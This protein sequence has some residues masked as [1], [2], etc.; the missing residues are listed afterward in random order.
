[1]TKGSKK[2]K[3]ITYK[4]GDILEVKTFA[5]PKIYKKVKNIINRESEWT[6][7]GK[8]K[9]EGFEGSFVRRKDLYAL[10]KSCVPYTGK[11]KLKDTISFTYNSQI[12]RV[13]S[14]KETKK[15]S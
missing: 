12:I 1:V 11:E 2:K 6:T 7:L 15:D 13:V 3:K 8:I 5:G 10:K 14:S 4:V 9:I